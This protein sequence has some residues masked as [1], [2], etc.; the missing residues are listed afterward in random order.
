MQAHLE[1]A[2]ILLPGTLLIYHPPLQDIHIQVVSD[3]LPVKAAPGA[4]YHSL[5]H[6]HLV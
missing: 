3:P 1:V 5:V 6:I 2:L 4:R